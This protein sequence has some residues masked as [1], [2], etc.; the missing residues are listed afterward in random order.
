MTGPVTHISIT[1]LTATGECVALTPS[2][3]LHGGF[4]RGLVISRLENVVVQYHAGSLA[5][6]LAGATVCHHATPRH[7]TPDTGES[8]G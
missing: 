3:R 6:L 4:A 1:H 2:D 8:L 5:G 7:V